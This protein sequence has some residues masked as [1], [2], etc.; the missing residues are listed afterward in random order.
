MNRALKL[1]SITQRLLVLVSGIL[2]AFMLSVDERDPYQDALSDIL[3][4]G[5]DGAQNLSNFMTSK[6][7]V[8]RRSEDE[9]LPIY[10]ASNETLRRFAKV[11]LGTMEELGARI[12]HEEVFSNTIFTD[13]KNQVLLKGWERPDLFISLPPVENP[14]VRR[15]LHYLERDNLKGKLLVLPWYEDYLIPPIKRALRKRNITLTRMT[16]VGVELLSNEFGK[17]RIEPL[18]AGTGW[19]WA[20]GLLRFSF[21]NRNPLGVPF[22]EL[23]VEVPLSLMQFSIEGDE[24]LELQ[25]AWYTSNGF[26]PEHYVLGD[27]PFADL[28]VLESQIGNMTMREAAEW[29]RQRAASN[30][31]SVNLLG[32]SLGDN[33][34]STV[35]PI[36]LSALMIGLAS[37]IHHI[38]SIASL[39]RLTHEDE[40]WGVVSPS[41]IARGTSFVAI[42]IVPGGTC[43]AMAVYFG[44]NVTVL[45]LNTIGALIA[46]AV[47]LSAVR[48]VSVLSV[49]KT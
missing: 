2:L 30:L 7:I 40:Y 46:M 10:Q 49:E 22:V 19:E 4:I 12:D 14:T 13:S 42:S 11:L 17:G 27:S 18:R 35:G 47:F 21:E 20:N 43:I 3:A 37:A 16:L 28:R 6:W 36:V 31:E 26:D 15:M 33:L 39:V 9:I 34:V 5:E 29:L 44:G 45:A 41:R 8:E 23:D 1:C 32:V 25:R 48:L 24:W 38:L